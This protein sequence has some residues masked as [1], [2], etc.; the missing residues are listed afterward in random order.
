MVR[1]NNYICMLS[2]LRMKSHK[3]NAEFLHLFSEVTDGLKFLTH[4]AV[5][6]LDYVDYVYR[7]QQLILSRRNELD[8]RDSLY[9]LVRGF[10]F[11]P[12]WTDYKGD[13]HHFFMSSEE[14]VSFFEETGKHPLNIPEYKQEFEDFR[15]SIRFRSGRLDLF[16]RDEL[17]KEFPSLDL[18]VSGSLRGADMYTETGAVRSAVRLILKSMQEYGE[19]PRVVVTYLEDE[20][21]DDLLKSTIIITQEG[22]FPAHPLSRDMGRLNEGDGGT[23]GTIRRALDGLCEWAVC[24]RWPDRD[25]ADRWRILR[26]ETEAELSPTELAEGFS[27]IIS[28]YHKP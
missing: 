28:I 4:E 22:S 3:D 20:A 25:G 8:I 19:H 23:F 11:G 5:G 26:D 14:A 9:E 24:S 10:V 17:A 1:K 21:G 13:V 27:H 15:N 18:A 12:K 7:C 2:G 6:A 16:F